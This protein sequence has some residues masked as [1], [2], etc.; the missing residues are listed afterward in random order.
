MSPPTLNLYL[1]KSLFSGPRRFLKFTVQNRIV[2]A[3]YIQQIT[4]N[5]IY[6]ND[7]NEN[8]SLLLDII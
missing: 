1:D 7:F 6:T 2:N 5:S 4:I 8:I 3:C